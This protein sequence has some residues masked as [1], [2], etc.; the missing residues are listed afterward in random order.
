[1]RNAAYIM[2]SLAVLVW[3][4]FVNDY[5]YGHFSPP[6]DQAVLRNSETAPVARARYAPQYPAILLFILDG[7][8]R[9]ALYDPS[10]CPEI[11]SRWSRFGLRY[12]NARA[13]LPS[14]S[15]PNYFSIMSGTPPSL[16]GIVNN[17]C[18]TRRDFYA[19]TVFQ[20]IADAGLG[21][22]VVGFDWYKEMFGHLVEYVPAE[23]CE[24]DDPAEVAGAVSTMIRCA[25]LP[26]FTVAHFLSPD[27]AAHAT[28]SNKSE[29]YLGSIRTIDSLLGG[30]FRQLD[31]VCPGA[32][33]II[34]SDHGMN[35]DGNHGGSDEA[36]MRVPLYML[37]PSLPHASV[38][39]TVR[40]AAIAPT[41][42][43]AA[44]AA[45]PSL[46]AV[47]PLIEALDGRAG[48]YLR[49]SIRLRERVLA[50]FRFMHPIIPAPKFAETE[51]SAGHDTRLTSAIMERT[52]RSKETLLLYQRLFFSL[53]LLF[54]AATVMRRR[55]AGTITVLLINGTMVA[56]AGVA[57]RVITSAHDYTAAASL[58]AIVISVIA[59]LCVALLRRSPL[60]LH[61]RVPGAFPDLFALLLLET[62]IIC[63]CFLPLYTF[64]PDENI[65]GVRFFALALWSPALFLS[66]VRLVIAIESRGFLLAGTGAVPPSGPNAHQHA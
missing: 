1:M 7:A 50:T 31:R 61:L 28:G 46:S 22:R 18:R 59:G 29:R 48:D 20:S 37:S 43:A 9:D 15:A 40:H 2:L 14:V 24:N 42:A 65:F 10:L 55:P 6:L 56:A 33:V 60:Y 27:N 8:V 19:P 36:S 53:S 5:R 63:A 3:L 26:F 30:I 62:A 11:T 64:S 17:D 44:G 21:S 41:V 47:P 4:L 32:L 38:S 54:F 23:C 13:M 39:R 45:L 16:H 12:E 34:A 49:E 52:E 51:D 35:V 57:M 66:I 58:Y 25:D